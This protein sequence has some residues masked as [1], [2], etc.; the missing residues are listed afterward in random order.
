MASRSS[1][2]IAPLAALTIWAAPA[3]G[4]SA[5]ECRHLDY[6]GNFRLNGAWQHLD[7]ARKT[8][9]PDV[10]QSRLADATR[11]LTDA[12][13]SGGGDQATLWYMFG[14]LYLM[15]ND[16]PGADSSFRKAEAITDPDCKREIIRERFNASV[17]IQNSADSLFG[18]NPDSALAL[19]RRANVIFRS[20]PTT[21]INMAN[22]FFSQGHEDSAIVYFRLAGRSTADRRYDE[23][24][25]LALFNVA[26]LLNRSAMDT[27]SV[28]AEAQRRG[29]ADSAVRMARFG[30]VEAAYREVLQM[31]PR[32]L[33]AQASLGAV[34]T[35]M[36]RDAEARTVYDSMLAHTDSM[37]AADLMD[38]GTALF[39]GKKYDLAARALELGL[40]KDRC[41]RDGLYNLANVYLAAKDSVHLLDA[42]RRLFAV[43]SMNRASLQ[44]LARA[45]QDNGNKDSTL[46]VLLRADSLAWEMSVIRFEPGDT[47]ATLHGIVTNLRPQPLKG[48]TLTVQFVNGACEPV[49]SQ[50]VELP[51]LGAN[52][53]AGQSYDFNLSVNGRGIA[54]WKYKT[55]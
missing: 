22:I 13:H 15:K 17:P 29:L 8:T 24:R 45:W 32:D 44:V 10:R 46:R 53:S 27:T 19:F 7:Q 34:L 40:A 18:S 47:S 54:A 37:D 4:Q 6:R 20:G 36:H 52:G 9:Y 51:D 5:P 41:D 33:P 1:L 39:N 43:D 55:N 25:E 3:L 38:A 26:R 11:L 12:A 42:A 16:L 28:H 35:E 48:F 21:F 49:A 31:R 30:E 14:Q 50:T 2:V 23:L